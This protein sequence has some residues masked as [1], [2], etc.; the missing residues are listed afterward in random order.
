MKGNHRAARID[1]QVSGISPP[2]RGGDVFSC[3]T[4]AGVT[5]RVLI[6]SRA[7]ENS[8]P[9]VFASRLQSVFQHANI[10]TR[11]FVSSHV[12]LRLHVKQNFAIVNKKI[13]NKA[14]ESEGEKRGKLCVRKW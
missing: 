1:P 11:V 7:T 6:I 12:I 4:A 8:V 5:K 14:R 10:T 2:S 3:E 13:A 9:G